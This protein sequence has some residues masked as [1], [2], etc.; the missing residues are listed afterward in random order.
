V[1][2]HAGAIEVQSTRGAGAR[3]RVLLPAAEAAR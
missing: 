1:T 2:A 3:F